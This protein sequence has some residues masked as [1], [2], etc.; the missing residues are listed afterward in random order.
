MFI[1][2]PNTV[3]AGNFKEGVVGVYQLYGVFVTNYQL[4]ANFLTNYQLWAS[5]FNNYQLSHCNEIFFTKTP[6]I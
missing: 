3:K 4:F 6:Q 5:N 2:S 1:I